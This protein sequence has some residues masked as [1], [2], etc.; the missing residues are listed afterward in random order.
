MLIVVTGG[1]GSGKSEACRILSRKYGYPVY[2][3]DSKVKDLYAAYPSIVETL[4][5]ELDC[6]LRNE[7]NKFV[8]SL[9]AARIFTDKS[10]LETVESVVFPY[11]LEDFRKFSE[12]NGGNIV[13]ESATILE[14]KAFADFGDYV[15]LIDAPVEV[16]LERACARDAADRKKV[17]SRMANQVLMNAISDG[18]IEDYPK[19]SELAAAYGRVNYRIMNEGS[20]DGLEASLDKVISEILKK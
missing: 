11:L 5:S 6:R 19:E 13:F 10:A 15:L 20:I 18:S 9:L 17:I 12:L 4:E 14:K 2:D 8:P 16:R 7:E 1:I 3:A